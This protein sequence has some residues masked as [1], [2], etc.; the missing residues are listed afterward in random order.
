MGFKVVGKGRLGQMTDSMKGQRGDLDSEDF[1]FFFCFLR[2][3]V[4]YMEAPRLRVE[5]ELQ[6]PAYI[7]THG[8]ARS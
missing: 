5:L 7:I 1:F 3:H 8:N 2:Q 6:L 4:Q